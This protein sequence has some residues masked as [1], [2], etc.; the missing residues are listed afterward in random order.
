ML[1]VRSIGGISHNK[2]EDTSE[3]DLVLATQALAESVDREIAR[4]APGA[5]SAA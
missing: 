2:A 4:Q 3:S 5:G 1:F